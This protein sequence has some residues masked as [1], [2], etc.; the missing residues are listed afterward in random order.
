MPRSHADRRSTSHRVTSA[1]RRARKADVETQ[2]PRD[3][4]LDLL[5]CG[6]Q[7]EEQRAVARFAEDSRDK[8]IARTVPTAATAVRE[9]HHALRSR[10]E[11]EH[12][13]Q[14]HCCAGNTH[15]EWCQVSFISGPMSNHSALLLMLTLFRCCYRG[16]RDAPSIQ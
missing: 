13:L 2:T 5:L 14:R 3:I 6:Q 10:R 9:D 1:S 11:S 15:L 16:F 8:L 4:V 12:S 7:I